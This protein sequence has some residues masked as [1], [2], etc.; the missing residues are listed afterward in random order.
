MGN[1]VIGFNWDPGEHT[2]SGHWFETTNF[3]VLAEDAEY[4]ELPFTAIHTVHPVGCF[5]QVGNK[6]GRKSA[7]SFFLTF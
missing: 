1:L 4:M 7:E 6:I 2:E 5:C 3:N